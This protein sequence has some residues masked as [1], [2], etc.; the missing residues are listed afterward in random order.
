MKRINAEIIT[1]GDEIL[2]GQILDTNTH[3][4]S[5]QLDS[6]GVRIVRK[7]TV[8][9]E[10]G[11]ILKVFAEAESR[12]DIILITGGLGPTNDDLTK[13]ALSKYFNSPLKIHEQALKELTDL[14]NARG[15][16]LTELNRQQAA[17]PECCKMISNKLGTATGMWF[18]KNGKVFISMPGVP[19]E[20]KAMM[21][22]SIIP[23]LK[24]FFKTQVIYHKM[25][26][27]VGIG[28]SW[29]A[30]MIRNWENNLPSHIKLAYL[31]SVAHVKLR[32]TASGTS[33][34]ELKKDVNE[35][36]QWLLP[37]AEK[38]IYGYDKTTLEEAVGILLKREKKTI[39]T[40]ESCTGGAVAQ[41]ITSIPG[42]SAYFKGGIIPYSNEIKEEILGVPK[43]TLV[44]YGAV[45]EETVKEMAAHV[46]K[47]FKADIGIAS[48]GIAGPSGGTPEKPVG[49]IWI[50]YND[51]ENIFAKKLL[52]GNDRLVNIEQATIAILNMIRL[53]ISKIHI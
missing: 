5:I 4:L 49:T 12:A 45:S 3:W 20:M 17:L 47:N 11:E 52:L 36:I 41:R 6:I 13:P 39:A 42:S 38:Y 21:E 35:Q 27:T 37:L 53:Q 29:L 10:E 32:L 1:I 34:E 30:D 28:E 44:S 26:K 7:T 46:R 18:E 50:A 33:K 31:P 14:F 24:N 25:I 8:G 19:H 23:S 48:S 16:E 43:S 40:A 2:Y 22:S 9:D 51:G 15:K